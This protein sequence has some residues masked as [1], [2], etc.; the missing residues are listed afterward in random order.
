MK[1]FSLLLISL[2]SHHCLAS[3]IKLKLNSF[4][5][6]VP[7]RQKDVFQQQPF[8]LAAKVSL[9]TIAVGQDLC[10]LYQIKKTITRFYVSHAQ[11]MQALVPVHVSSSTPFGIVFFD[12]SSI[13]LRLSRCL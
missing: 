5:I 10:R 1:L 9:Q 4:H 13:A 2:I 6:Q 3:Q 7:P 12:P 11:S 8:Q